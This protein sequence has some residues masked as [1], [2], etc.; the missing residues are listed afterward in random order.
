MKSTAP[1]NLSAALQKRPEDP[2]F[3]RRA[4]AAGEKKKKRKK[5]VGLGRAVQARGRFRQYCSAGPAA[6]SEWV[7]SYDVCGGSCECAQGFPD[8]VP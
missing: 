4:T 5:K 3:E 1:G 7:L 2:F 8:A 6:G